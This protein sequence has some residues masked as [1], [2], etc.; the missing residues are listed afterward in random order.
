M[1]PGMR[2]ATGWMA[3]ETS[4][5]RCL[6]Q[7]GQLAD[8]VLRLGHGEAVAGHDDDLLGVGQLDRRVVEADLAHGAACAASAGRAG[9][10]VAATEAADHDVRDRPVHGV[11]HE[12]GQDRARGTHQGA[13]DDQHRVADDE[14]RHRRGR[15]R[16]RV[17]EAR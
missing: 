12:L 14:A 15:A 2:P 9:S 3:Y 1:W 7:L 13:G 16:E 10:G 8:R 11:G 5:P 4:T 6:E 17:Q